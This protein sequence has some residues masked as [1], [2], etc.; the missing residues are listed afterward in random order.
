MWLTLQTNFDE[1]IKCGGD[2]MYKIKHMNKAKLE[3]KGRLPTVITVSK[4]A[5]QA[6]ED[7]ADAD[8]ELTKEELA[9]ANAIDKMLQQDNI[10][11]PDAISKEELKAL[12]E[13]ADSDENSP[14]CT[15][16]NSDSSS[17]ILD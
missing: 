8:Y 11:L 16:P 3:R 1:I 5:R 9:E 14:H 2:N 13:E 7:Q 10:E 12:Q 6:L 17:N 4:D 15:D